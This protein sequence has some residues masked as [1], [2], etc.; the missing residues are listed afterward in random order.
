MAIETVVLKLRRGPYGDF[1]TDKQK[2]SE[3]EPCAVLSGDPSVPSGKA[4]YVCF[5]AGD[6]RR[7]VSLEDLE[8]MADRGDFK[9]EKGDQGT[10]IKTLKVNAQSHLIVT[11]TDNTQVDAGYVL[12]ILEQINASEQLRIQAERARVSAETS[13]AS[14]EASRKTAETA[15]DNAEQTR[16]SNE[17]TRKSN[18][19]VRVSNEAARKSSEAAR[20]QAEQERKTAD[21]ARNTL[22]AENLKPAVE[23]AVKDADTAAD[24]ANTVAE[25][26]ISRRDAG[27]FK[28]DK[29]E[30]FKYTDFT[31]A[32]LAAL[33]GPKGETGN[34]GPQGERGEPFTYADFTAEQLAALKGPKGDT[35][36]RGLKGDKGSPFTYADFTA[37]QLAALKGPKGDTGATGPQGPQ[38]L[39]GDAGAP[40]PQGPQGLKGDTGPTGPKGPQ[41][42]KGDTGA[43]GARGATGP[44]GPKGDT[45]AAAGFGT[46][47]ASVDANVGTPSV[48]VTASGANTARVF[49][50]A[51]KNL[52]GATGATGPRGA[53]GATG[54]TG[55]Q[56]PKGNTGATGPQGPAG[57]NATTTAA[58]TQSAN[59]LMSA[60][61]KKKLDG[62]A[63]GAQVNSV[64]GVKGNS[65]SSYRTGNVNITAANVG[66]AAST[67]YHR[68]LVRSG[69]TA[70][71]EVGDAGGSQLYSLRPA[72]GAGDNKVNLGTSSYRFS[73]AYVAAGSISTSDRYEKKEIQ[74][75]NKKIE[76]F[77][78]NLRPVSYRWKYDEDTSTHYGFIAQEIAQAGT[79]SLLTTD[80]M[81]LLSA[82]ELENPLEDGREIR[83]GLNY[84]EF[85]AIEVHMIQKLFSGVEELERRL[86][87]L[88]NR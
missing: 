44:Q 48:T 34:T 51:F 49:S 18:E 77:F 9:G 28:G 2:L 70:A 31:Q 66:A 19:T 82:D 10:G 30:P 58:A 87:E 68:V 3:G 63:A 55:P 8:I 24:H 4:F 6:V 54:A 56:G 62:M 37:D 40:G 88:E 61:D 76:N 7:M 45:G 47:T 20:E 50:F 59:G 69:S 83:W 81:G 27:E 80:D 65:E 86:E 78:M 73:H 29:G 22:W 15:R 74:D 52:K 1:I 36:E 39:K 46:P 75:L 14:A 25:D 26:L 33:T 79:S 13:R 42:L 85:H 16:I 60:A 67:H 17:N 21:S 72:S 84:A 35:G 11:L 41:G 71:V 64:T 23:Q 12:D 32:Q 43:A 53:T 38:G 5:Q 57:V